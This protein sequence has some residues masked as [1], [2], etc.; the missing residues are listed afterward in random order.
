MRVRGPLRGCFRPCLAWRR[1]WVRARRPPRRRAAAGDRRV[2]AAGAVT[3]ASPRL[4][5][6]P[7]HA[8]WAATTRSSAAAAT[9]LAALSR[10]DAGFCGFRR[11]RIDCS[12]TFA[13]RYDA[14]VGGSATD[15]THAGTRTSGLLVHSNRRLRLYRALPDLE[16][17]VRFWRN[18]FRRNVDRSILA[19]HNDFR[20][21]LT[22]EVARH[23]R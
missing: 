4:T 14:F 9:V 20:G 13:A 7:R 18:R 22:R 8:V 6:G 3:A 2:A 5:A 21:N 16:A 11:R 15:R 23:T 1:P 19:R 10:A 17:R 12:G